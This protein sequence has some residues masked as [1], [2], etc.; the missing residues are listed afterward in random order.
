MWLE[1][2]TGVLGRSKTLQLISLQINDALHG[3]TS[4]RFNAL[5]SKL[6]Y[7]SMEVFHLLLPVE[8][9]CTV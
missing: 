6:K 7:G 1:L 9:P 8:G 5:N 4:M 2:Y 3:H